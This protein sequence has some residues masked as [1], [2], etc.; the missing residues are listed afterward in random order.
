MKILGISC[1][2]RQ[3][4][5]TEILMTEA[6]FAA[7]QAGAETEMVSVIG[8]DI[9]PCDGCGIC[10]QIGSCVIDDDM[11]AILR[12][13]EEAD[14][15]LLGSP[16]YFLSVSAQAKIIMDRTNVFLKDRRLKGKVAASIIAVRRVGGGMTRTLMYNYFITH[17]M[18]P[19][20]GALGYGMDVGDVTQ[21]VGGA[22]GSTALG[23]ARDTAKEVIQMVQYLSRP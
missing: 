5:N 11:Q 13:M 8:K 16:V 12:Q 10:R 3:G 18:I 22:P 20:K 9:A 1:S 7:K 2:P 4:G 19:V 17:G 21:G 15:I 23:E 6:L 14:A